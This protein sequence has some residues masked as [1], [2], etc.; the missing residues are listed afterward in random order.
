MLVSSSRCRNR[1]LDEYASLFA[2]LGDELRL[3]LIETLSLGGLKSTAE[4]TAGMKLSGTQISRQGVT[5]HLSV[6]AAAGWLR[7]VKV[8]RER[9][10]EIEPAQLA[11]A[12]RSLKLIGRPTESAIEERGAGDEGQHA[13][14]TG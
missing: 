6:L 3:R 9:L 10:W 13:K 7:D 8:G 14:G 1:R 5:K 11:Q 12:H 2:A 4:L